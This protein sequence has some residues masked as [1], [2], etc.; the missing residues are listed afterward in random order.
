MPREPATYLFESVL[1]VLNE[2]SRAQ[3]KQWWTVP[4]ETPTGREEM[5]HDA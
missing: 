5:R 1:E 4:S 3:T 2:A